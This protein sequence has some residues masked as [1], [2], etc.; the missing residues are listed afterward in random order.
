[1]T[2]RR[3]RGQGGG[4]W[5]LIV[6]LALVAVLVLGAGVWFL[7]ARPDLPAV[8]TAAAKSAW[9]GQAQGGALLDASGYVVARREATVSAKVTGKVERVLI[10]EGQHVASGQ[11][12]ATLDDSNTRAALDQAAAQARSADANIRVAQVTLA[13][14]TPKYARSRSLHGGGWLSDQDLETAQG[15]FD[16][17]RENLAL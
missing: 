4:R 15:T 7:V 3:R 2:R 8:S 11:V 6:G 5:P 9:N 13:E 10:Q 16:A 12:I 1:P 17:A 14:E